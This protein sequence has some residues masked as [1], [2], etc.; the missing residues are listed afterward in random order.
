[1]PCSFK[2]KKESIKGGH[3]DWND[4]DCN[5]DYEE[6]REYLTPTIYMTTFYNTGSFESKQFG[7]DSI[8]KEVAK[9][10]V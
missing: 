3:A 10:T 7:D 4:R 9:K 5:Q 2:P 6:A 1:M 8:K